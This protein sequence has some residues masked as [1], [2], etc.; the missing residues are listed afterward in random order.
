V[1]VELICD[2]AMIATLSGML[3]REGEL[4]LCH[5]CDSSD[6]IEGILV[7]R[8]AQEACLVCGRCLEQNRSGVPLAS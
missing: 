1:D 4:M 8:E 7:A 5:C 6:Q 2:P 3:R